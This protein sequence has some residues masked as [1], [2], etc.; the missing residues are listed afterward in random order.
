MSYIGKMAEHAMPI[1]Y[2]EM[3]VLRTSRTII[4]HAASLLRIK[5]IPVVLPGVIE[6]PDGLARGLEVKLS[7]LAQSL[8][9]NSIRRWGIQ[10]EVLVLRGDSQNDIGFHGNPWDP[11]D[12]LPWDFI[13]VHATDGSVEVTTA[14]ALEPAYAQAGADVDARLTELLRQNKTDPRYADPNT[15]YRAQ[16]SDAAAIAFPSYLDGSNGFTCL[17]DFRTISQ[18]RISLLADIVSLPPGVS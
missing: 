18:N 4:E 16:L 8:N 13:R 11:E 14:T 17:H 6:S 10:Q 3:P 12:P 2:K 5:R 15:F 9:R 7:Y 1:S